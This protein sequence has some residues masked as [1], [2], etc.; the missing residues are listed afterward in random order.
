MY[1]VL[2]SLGYPKS[3]DCVVKVSKGQAEDDDNRIVANGGVIASGD[4]IDGRYEG[5]KGMSSK[6]GMP[7][8][9]SSKKG[10]VSKDT[11]AHAMNG[12]KSKGS[13]PLVGHDRWLSSRTTRGTKYVR[14][15][16]G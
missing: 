8:S 15:I 4:D 13:H 12:K 9:M 11:E 16:Y 1:G 5:T 3:D 10:M 14:S 2:A 7:G 6:K